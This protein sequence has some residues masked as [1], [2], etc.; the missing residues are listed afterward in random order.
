[1]SVPWHSRNLKGDGIGSVKI[2][3]NENLL[4]LS[5]KTA[6]ATYTGSIPTCTISAKRNWA[7]FA[8]YGSWIAIDGG[9]GGDSGG[10]GNNPNNQYNNV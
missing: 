5:L 8:T 9:G 3:A 4:S 7:A 10:E 1:M 6:L 2:A